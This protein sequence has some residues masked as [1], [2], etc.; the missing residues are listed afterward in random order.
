MVKQVCLMESISDTEYSVGA[1]NPEH[2]RAVAA[3][4]HSK[5]L[6]SKLDNRDTLREIGGGRLAN[7]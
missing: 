7:R 6:G 1:I 2:K 3:E 4:D 5:T